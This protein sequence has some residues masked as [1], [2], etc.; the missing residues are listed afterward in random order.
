MVSGAAW[1]KLD[2]LANGVELHESVAARCMSGGVAVRRNVYNTPLWKGASRE[3]PQEIRLG[4]SIFAVNVCGPSPWLLVHASDRDGVE[5]RH[6]PTGTVLAGEYIADLGILKGPPHSETA[7][8]YGGA[9]LAFFSPRSCY[10]FGDKTE[11]GFCSLA[12]TAKDTGDFRALI[13][14]EHV[15][16]TVSATLEDRS[17]RDRI[18][19]VMIVG[20]N[21]RD[22]DRGFR[23]HVGLGRAAAEALKAAS[24][25]NQVSVHIATMPPRDLDLIRSLEEIENSPHVMFNLEVW[26]AELFQALCPGKDADYG[27][28]GILDALSALRD[29]V[30]A[31]NAHSLLIAG[32]EPPGSTLEGARRL[33]S[34]G[35]SPIINIYHSDRHSRL[36]LGSRPTLGHLKEVAEGLQELHQMHPITPYWENC[37]RNAIDMEARRRAFSEPFPSFLSV[38]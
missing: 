7:N 15:F 28:Q 3:A 35:I 12:G 19:Q 21:M 27:R 37:G 6:I 36:G 9:A 30:G 8:L 38:Q 18:E 4:A 5:V 22:L 2:L 13:T 24:M 16:E 29:V 20:G 23:H 33:A 10:F 32:L 14:P 17:A 34:E 1:V 31:F 26:D 25:L 11:C